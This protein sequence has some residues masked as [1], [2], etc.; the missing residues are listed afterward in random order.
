M[1]FPLF[2]R[3]TIAP[4][5][6]SDSD[7]NKSNIN[8]ND[9]NNKEKK[10]KKNSSRLGKCRPTMARVA[11]AAL[12]LAC[13]LACLQFASYDAAALVRSVKSSDRPGTHGVQCETSQG[14]LR[15]QLLPESTPQGVQRFVDMVRAGFFTDIAMFRCID[16][17][18]AQFGISDDAD[19]NRQFEKVIPDDGEEGQSF[20]KQRPGLADH[21]AL[22]DPGGP[23][24]ELGPPPLGATRRQ[25]GRGQGCVGSALPWLR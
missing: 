10:N 5:S 1:P 13:I 15:F 14:R 21:A 7:T 2:S 20:E 23:N 4:D 8:S 6:K 18:L 19:A 11:G 9:E 16:G 22:C 17:F 3:S 12:F 24:R 25:V